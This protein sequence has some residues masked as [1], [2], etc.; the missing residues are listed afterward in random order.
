MGFGL[1]LIKT[2]DISFISPFL[3]LVPMVTVILSFLIFGEE[4][5]IEFIFI[6]SIIIFGIFL[7]FISTNKKLKKE[8]NGYIK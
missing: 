5:N 3:L 4:V 2:E 6:A 1:Y 7:V 8:K